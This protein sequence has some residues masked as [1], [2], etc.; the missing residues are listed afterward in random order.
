MKLFL[1]GN[2]QN[3]STLHLPHHPLPTL[4]NIEK[5]TNKSYTWKIP[6]T[7]CF[8]IYVPFPC[9][10]HPLS[11]PEDMADPMAWLASGP[12]DAMGSAVAAASTVG[13]AEL[14]PH[15][16]DTHVIRIDEGKVLGRLGP[17]PTQV[18]SNLFATSMINLC[19]ASPL[20]GIPCSLPTQGS[21]RKE[22]HD[23]HD[24]IARVVDK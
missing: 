10:A 7:I 8:T 22:S 19:L 5:P 20:A 18:R 9:E 24:S 6:P 13:G 11:P 16:D 2:K 23:R 12:W 4:T 17:T 15:N 3:L 21:T 1:I 14:W